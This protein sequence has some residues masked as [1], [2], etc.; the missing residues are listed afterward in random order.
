M[1]R[2]QTAWDRGCRRFPAIDGTQIEPPSDAILTPGDIGCLRSH[3]AI[4]TDFR[5]APRLSVSKTIACGTALLRL[6]SEY[7]VKLPASRHLPLFGDD[8]AIGRTEFVSR[9]TSR[10]RDRSGRRMLMR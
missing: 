4:V 1:V 5:D 10:W 2:V 3:L 8:Q 7:A 6:F 9:A